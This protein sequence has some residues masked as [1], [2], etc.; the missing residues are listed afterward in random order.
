MSPHLVFGAV[1]RRTCARCCCLARVWTQL[2]RIFLVVQLLFA[3]LVRTCARACL[4]LPFQVSVVVGTR[5]RLRAHVSVSCLLLLACCNKSVTSLVSCL[6]FVTCLYKCFARNWCVVV[7]VS[8]ASA[9]VPFCVCARMLVRTVCVLV[10]FTGTC[11][12]RLFAGCANCYV[13]V[14][15]ILRVSLQM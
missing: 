5:L 11:F 13:F 14:V 4:L 2:T 8:C 15:C 9:Q 3:C 12:L 6:L 7:V 10:L 1:V